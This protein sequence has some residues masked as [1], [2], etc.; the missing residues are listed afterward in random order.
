MP[1]FACHL[2][3]YTP[4]LMQ[5]MLNRNEFVNF[6]KA[7]SVSMARVLWLR[8]IART[9]QWEIGERVFLMF[10]F[11]P[12]LLPSVSLCVRNRECASPPS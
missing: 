1:T 2:G 12:S 4:D 9:F 5:N 8:K 3:S 11:G 10:S 7:F 6:R